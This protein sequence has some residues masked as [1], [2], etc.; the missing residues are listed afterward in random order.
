MTVFRLGVKL[1]AIAAAIGARCLIG[2]G[3]A[4]GKTVELID[5][6]SG[7]P[8]VKTSDALSK[9]NASEAQTQHA[10]R[11]GYRAR[12]DDAAPARHVP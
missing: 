12:R 5:K 1:A 9:S 10:R 2:C 3:H 11:I 8:S 6:R 7:A 4:V